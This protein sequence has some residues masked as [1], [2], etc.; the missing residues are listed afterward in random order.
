MSS[1]V[2]I[3]GYGPAVG[4]AILNRLLSEP[5]R[6]FKVALV[7]RNTERL[8]IESEEWKAKGKEVKGFF[9]DLSKPETIPSLIEDIETTFGKIDI[10]I[11][12]ATVLNQSYSASPVEIAKGININIVSFHVVFNTLVTKWQ[13]RESGGRFLSTGG[14]LGENGAWSVPYQAQFGAATKAYFK[15]FAESALATFQDKRILVGNII[16]VGLVYGGD[17][18]TFDDPNPKQSEIFRQQVGD[19]FYH[20]LIS[21]VDDWKANVKVLDASLDAS[22]A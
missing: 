5:S 10:A 18:L 9:G 11:Y 22:F 4:N 1:V 2:V 3:F 14:G 7:A 16:V 19:A 8:D 21:D 20:Q 6:E 13:E 12:N 15:N 17:S